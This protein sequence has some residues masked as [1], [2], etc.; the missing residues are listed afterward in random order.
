MN[1]NNVDTICPLSPLQHGMLHASRQERGSGLYVEQFSCVLAGALDA[2][3]F[4]AAWQAV[5]ERHDVLKTLFL[6]LD[7]DKPVQVVR[8][9][10][11]L[12]FLVEDWTAEPGDEA[13]R[14]AAL[15]ADDRRTGFDPAVEPLM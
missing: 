7:T 13:I 8:K 4:R 14:F 1:A 12:P 5:V 9:S 3:A 6:R 2:E 10:V 15:L 11:T